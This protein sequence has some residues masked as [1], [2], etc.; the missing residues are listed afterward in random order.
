MQTFI[1]LFNLHGQQQIYLIKILS[2]TT[3]CVP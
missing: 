1:F 3:R 2:L